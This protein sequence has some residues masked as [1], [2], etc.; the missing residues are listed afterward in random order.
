M[1]LFLHELRGE[2][3]L[4][5][6]SRELAFFTFLLPIIFFLILGSA[7][8]EE[9]IDGY[10]GADYLLTG[11]M[12]YGVAATAFAGLAIVIVIRREEGILKRLRATPL[13]ASTYLAALLGT[14]II[15]FLVEVVVLIGLG[16]AFLDA[17]FPKAVFS[18]ALAL[19]LGASA[20]AA[21]GVGVTALIRRSEG[22]SAVI[23]AIYLPASFLSGAFF[24]QHAFP[25]F[26]TAIANL[27]PLSYFI[28]LMGAITLDGRAIWEEPVDVAVIAAWGL[29]GAVLAVR[30]FRWIPTEG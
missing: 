1:S 14:T 25:D 20:F 11:M 8:G 17:S 3:K 10:R 19:L 22:A 13:P 28:D 4:Y 29:A 16:V 2:L 6:R 12:G 7:Y 23:N 9:D 21:L 5:V 15:A 26:L 30:R 27:L 24:S 18:L